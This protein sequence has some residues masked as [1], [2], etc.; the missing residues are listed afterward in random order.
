MPMDFWETLGISATADKAEIKNAYINKLKL[1][2]I[3]TFSKSFEELKYAYRQAII[4]SR[5]LTISDVNT[6]PLTTRCDSSSSKAEPLVFDPVTNQEELKNALVKLYCDV[7]NRNSPSC[8]LRLFTHVLNQSLSNEKQIEFEHHIIQFI[9]VN[10]LLASSVLEVVAD[11]FF[12]SQTFE[13]FQG[14]KLE[15]PIRYL[16]GILNTRY[17]RIDENTGLHHSDLDIHLQQWRARRYIEDNWLFGNISCDELVGKYAEHFDL[18]NDPE[19]T[20]FVARKCQEKGNH[21]LVQQVLPE[22]LISPEHSEAWLIL[23]NSWFEQEEFPK[24]LECYQKASGELQAKSRQLR[25][26]RISQCFYKLGYYEAA[27]ALMPSILDD[28]PYDF[29]IRQQLHL[30]SNKVIAVWESAGDPDSHYQIA[31]LLFDSGQYAKCEAILSPN[32]EQWI[33]SGDSLY[34]RSLAKQKKYQEAGEIFNQMVEAARK[35]G[36]NVAHIAFEYIRNCYHHYWYNQLLNITSN[37][38]ELAQMAAFSSSD[39]YAMA[40]IHEC[41]ISALDLQDEQKH[42]AYINACKFIDIAVGMDYENSQFHFLRTILKFEVDDFEA[43]AESGYPALS[44]ARYDYKINRC[45]AFS[46]YYLNRHEEAASRLEFYLEMKLEE[47]EALLVR[48][49]LIHSSAAIGNIERV[50]QLWLTNSD[51]QS[52]SLDSLQEAMPLIVDFLKKREQAVSTDLLQ[53]ILDV[54]QHPVF[55]STENQDTLSDLAALFQ[56]AVLKCDPSEA[57]DLHH[58]RHQYDQRFGFLQHRS[59]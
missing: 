57:E 41:R 8:W 29:A 21:D 16:F 37:M 11:F 7:E 6:R 24:A 54:M 26:Q 31:E 58:L 59:Q 17:H 19:L 23:A 5:H 28:C 2:D 33:L 15:D 18:K 55:L 45:L 10:N 52:A 43:A 1:I 46:L 42:E 30:A 12:L 53:L 51:G 20:C 25:D 49:K 36:D 35:C 9:A 14:G 27:C 38:D 56:M 22:Q 4:K 50:F 34:A 40:R 3:S 47:D 48:E 13:K 32:E 39:A 44:I